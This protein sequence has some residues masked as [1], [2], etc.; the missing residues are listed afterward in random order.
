MSEVTVPVFSDFIVP[1]LND[2]SEF[3]HF[4]ISQPFVQGQFDSG[5]QPEFGL[6]IWASDMNMDSSLFPGKKEKPILLIPKNGR[7]HASNV[8]R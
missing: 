8:S 7:T 2:V 1:F 6:P 5:F 4:A 3:S